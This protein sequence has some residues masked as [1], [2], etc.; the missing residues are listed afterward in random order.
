MV[1]I[2][3]NTKSML[4]ILNDIVFLN[5]IF[6]S[7]FINKFRCKNKFL[8]VSIIKEDAKLKPHAAV[9]IM[10]VDYVMMLIIKGLNFLDVKYSRWILQK[11]ILLNA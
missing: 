11:Y 2:S 9:F 1:I 4:V 5:N 3:I 10:F 6:C 8:D 7:S